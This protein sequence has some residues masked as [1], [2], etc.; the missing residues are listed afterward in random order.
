VRK[1]DVDPR[2]LRDLVERVFGNGSQTTIERTPDGVST[3]VY[4]IERPG[5]RFYLRIAEDREDLLAADVHVHTLLAAR[6]VHVP[7]VV[8]YEPFDTALDRSVMVTTEIPGRSLAGH[9]SGIDVGQVLVAAGRDLATINE[10]VVAGFG[11]VQRD[12]PRVDR[13]E[14]ELPTLRAF[15][16]ETVGQDLAAFASFAP[17]GDVE[18]VREIL[19]RHDRWL[20]ETDGRLAHGDFDANHVYHQDGAYSGIIDLG[21]MRGADRR[22]D[23]GHFALHDGEHVPARGLSHVLEG[24][25]QISPLSGED[26]RPIRFWSVLIGLRLLA[27]TRGRASARYQAQW[28]EAIGR[29]ARILGG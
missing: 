14:A 19:D 10:L 20:D 7:E 15:V 12:R 2:A 26:E 24:Y 11:W 1:P 18:R 4:R 28:V 16:D 25:R 6:G 13:L 5:E 3:Q 27:R 17:G 22:Y 9:H 29:E 8:H 23:L 21:E